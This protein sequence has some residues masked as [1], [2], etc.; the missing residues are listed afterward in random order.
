MNK[1]RML[2]SVDIDVHNYWRN[3]DTNMS[4]LVND[5]LKGMMLMDEENHDLAEL[6]LE[7]QELKK[8]MRELEKQLTTIVTKISKEQSNKEKENLQYK[9]EYEEMAKEAQAWKANNPLRFD[10][11]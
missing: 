2:I 6:K 3:K 8:E 4:K 7:E 10:R 1:T 11:K 9:K 5:Y